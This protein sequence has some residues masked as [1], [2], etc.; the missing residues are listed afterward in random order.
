MMVTWAPSFLLVK[1]NASWMD[2]FVRQ[3]NTFDVNVLVGVG[4]GL[5]APLVRDVG[6]R[7]LQAISS[8]VKALVSKAQAGELE[9]HQVRNIGYRYT[10]FIA[11]SRY[12]FRFLGCIDFEIAV[13]GGCFFSFSSAAQKTVGFCLCHPTAERLQRGTSN[14]VRFCMFASLSVMSQLGPNGRHSR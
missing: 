14:L 11:L 9:A 1:V 10:D 2:T 5:V 12:A 7:G 3:Y 4:D 6:G 13:V 8:E